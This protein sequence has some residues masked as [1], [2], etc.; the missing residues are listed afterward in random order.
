MRCEDVFNDEDCFNQYY[1][2]I[3]YRRKRTELNPYVY[4]DDPRNQLGL[5]DF[6]GMEERY[7]NKGIKGGALDFIQKP[8]DTLVDMTTQ[9][10]VTPINNILANPF[11]SSGVPQVD[12]LIQ[13][14]MKVVANHINDV[15][16][17]YTP[18][19][20]QIY[21]AYKHLNT[22]SVASANTT[23]IPEQTRN[24]AILN[25]VTA[26]LD[27]TNNIGLAQR[28]LQR[29][30]LNNKY[31]LIQN[32]E[33]GAI[34]LNTDTNKYVVSYR[35]TNPKNPKDLV[36]DGY[37][38]G[39]IERQ[40]I[41]Y[42]KANKL[43]DT[44][45]ELGGVEFITGYS[46]GGNHAI[47]MAYDKGVPAEVFNAGVSVDIVSRSRNLPVETQKLITMY[48]TADDFASALRP[49][50]KG[51]KVNVID[52]YKPSLNPLDSHR[53]VENFIDNKSTLTL[54]NRLSV[55]DQAIVT[56]DIAR[57]YK[58]ASEID[59][60]VLEGRHTFTEYIDLYHPT[61]DIRELPSTTGEGAS[62]SSTPL[63]SE[64]IAK[65]TDLINDDLRLKL[66]KETGGSFTSQELTLLKKLPS[67]IDKVILTTQEERQSFLELPVL[68]QVNEIRKFQDHAQITHEVASEREL[69]K[70]SMFEEAQRRVNPVN[71]AKAVGMGAGRLV[72][73]T[74]ALYGIEKL[75][76]QLGLQDVNPV[77]KMT[78]QAGVLG[79]SGAVFAGLEGTAQAV[80]AGI[81]GGSF[82]AGVAGER[83][84]NFGLE[85]LGVDKDIR[86][87][88]SGIAG[89]AIGGAS[90]PYLTAGL[91][92]ASE[93]AGATLAGTELVGTGIL[94]T[95]ITGVSGVLASTGFGA[96][97]A[98]AVFGGFK[99]IEA[100]QINNQFEEFKEQ[101]KGTTLHTND[102]LL[103][104][105]FDRKKSIISPEYT[106][107]M[108]IATDNH[109]PPEL[110]RVANAIINNDFS[111]ITQEQQLNFIREALPEQY[112]KRQQ[113]LEDI[114]Q[115]EIQI[116]NS[117]KELPI[118]RAVAQAL[119]DKNYSNITEK[120]FVNFEKYTDI[121]TIKDIA[122]N[123]KNPSNIR[124]VA[125][126]ILDGKLDDI[127]DEQL[128]AYHYYL[129]PQEEK[130]FSLS[131]KTQDIDEEI[132]M[133]HSKKVDTETD[134][135][136]AMARL[137]DLEQQKM[138]IYEEYRPPSSQFV[139][140]D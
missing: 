24:L 34:Y 102:L 39:G 139:F 100:I 82:I 49:F 37:I 35:G 91:G 89:G 88:I 74:G 17:K 57:E 110:K 129:D 132:D 136:L 9:E 107:I 103:H 128:E 1:P 29:Y 120:D 47:H 76:E 99:L 46:K 101:Y 80:G 84:I 40:H 7:F 112:K 2:S 23:Q 41:D 122:Y 115:Q 83:A 19:Q 14:K 75:N 31:T 135:Y 70:M 114:R 51:A 8:V 85:N 12:S 25:E 63:P 4:K 90:V 48:S 105:M 131:K 124:A 30:N 6:Q 65:P 20:Q 67:N 68:E 54:E 77:L 16:N 53:L 11:I 5:D 45:K 138:D 97:M 72:V 119:L 36:S 43:F 22:S 33:I 27:S 44:A 62:S 79:A 133:I 50:V 18:Q 28:F 127:G 78:E 38:A 98:G 21:Q 126:A 60:I 109:T 59:A 111:K 137:D 125:Q 10:I 3:D 93:Y 92:I 61:T 56:N 118:N 66:W 94:A 117:E 106:H 73:E 108:D 95:S 81:G 87:P 104:E 13:D 140:V 134:G 113:H 121:E 96:L 116:A 71:I 69:I 130:N 55:R 123:D 64:F 52:Q 32:Q 86:D 15:Y 26:K 42:R 58:L